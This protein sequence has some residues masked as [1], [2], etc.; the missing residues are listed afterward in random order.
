MLRSV[1]LA[2]AT[3]VL[4]AQTPAPEV[5]K[6]TS[7]PAASA[8]AVK[9][10]K[11]A[12]TA[13][14]AKAAP[15]P[16][17][18]TIGKDV[19]RES[20]FELFLDTTMTDQQRMQLQFIDGARDQ[21]LSRFLDFKAMAVKARKEGLQNRPD[22]AKKLAVM[23]MQLL[24][25][26]LM[27]RDGPALQSK[28]ALKDEEV[29]A[30]FDAHPDKFR[31]PETFTARHILIGTRAVGDQK[32]LTEAEAK[33]KVDKVLAEIKGGKT[34]EAA[35][36]EYSDDPGSKDNGG[37]YEDTA[38]GKFVP[39]FDQAVRSQAIGKVGDPVKTMYG[40]HLIEVEKITPAVAQ[41]FDQVKDAAKE[42]A[43]ADRQ[44]QVYQAYT[45]K[46]RKEVGLKMSSAPKKAAQ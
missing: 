26:A 16:V 38:F 14:T 30:Y 18:A 20:D 15:D 29:K 27:E 43:T 25:Q 6:A 2:T 4:A 17:L 40:Y 8:K 7:A 19:V 42:Q 39:E 36:K 1:I 28:L 46:V 5:P 9:P 34:F 22:H 12:K 11:S 10:A 35:A 24:I 13:K 31:T 3:L 33:A 41:T 32:A 37:L 23:D 21:Y 44:E 45:E